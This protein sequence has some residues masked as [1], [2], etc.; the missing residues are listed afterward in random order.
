MS[1]PCKPFAARLLSLKAHW[2][3]ATR[4]K[5]VTLDKDAHTSICVAPGKLTALEL[6]V[7]VDTHEDE[8]R[9]LSLGLYPT[10]NPDTWRI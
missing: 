2:K 10:P 4:G 6:M 8:N 7:L 5:R 3:T 1:K 9:N